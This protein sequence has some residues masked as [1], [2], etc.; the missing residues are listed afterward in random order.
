MIKK[1]ILLTVFHFVIAIQMLS[2]QQKL[3]GTI[4]DQA[5]S[6]ESATVILLDKDSTM[7]SFALSDD[8]GAFVF[9]GLDQTE[10]ILQ[11]SFMS[12]ADYSTSIN[13]KPSESLD[14]GKIYLEESS[15]I[16][17]E[18]TIKAE[19][20][21]IGIKGDTINY[22]AAAF[23][24]KP[25]ATVEELLKKMPG[26]EVGRDGSIK[27]QGEEV[28]NVLVDG[29]EFFGKDPKIATQ[30]LEAE[31][32]DKVQVFD[33][34][35]ELAEFTGIEDGKEE[36]TI[37]LKLKDGYKNGGFGNI[38]L[39]GGTEDR[40]QSKLSYNRFSPK[41][42]SSILFSANNINKQA[43]S[44]NEYIS[45]M[46]GLNSAINNMMS[47]MN[48]SEFSNGRAPQGLSNDISGGLNFNYDF[49]EKVQ[50]TSN[51][52][53]FEKKLNLL[54][55]NKSIQF[56][57]NNEFASSDEE[58]NSN[59]TRNHKINT[60][61]LIKPS[62]LIQW[63]LRN[64]LGIRSTSNSSFQ[65]SEFED[66]FG[67]NTTTLDQNLESSGLDYN[68]E[69]Q[70][71]KKY[72]KKGRNWINSIKYHNAQVEDQTNIDNLYFV[73]QENFSLNQF[74]AFDNVLKRWEGESAFT[75][76][77]NKLNFVSLKYAYKSEEESPEKAFYDIVDNQ[78]ILNTTLSDVFT[79]SLSTHQIGLSFRR[80]KKKNK[81]A[82]GINQ[83]WITLETQ[84][85]L[86]L[87][88]YARQ[89]RFV[90]PYAN[91]DIEVARNTKIDL[92]YQSRTEVPGIQQLISI[93][94][95]TNPKLLRIGNPGLRPAQI[96][97]FRIGY[98][99]FNNFDFKNLFASVS[100][101]SIVDRVVYSLSFDDNLL[102]TSKP[103]NSS[104]Y[105]NGNL[106]FTYSAPIRKLGIKYRLS[107]R[108]DWSD[109]ESFLNNE[110]SQVFE[111]E[112]SLSLTFENRKKKNFDVLFGI[113]SGIQSRA[114]QINPMFDQR[115]LNTSAFAD[116]NWFLPNNWTLTSSF[117]YTQFSNQSFSAP[118]GFKLW[119]ASVQKGFKDN[120]F[121]IKATAFDL[122]KQNVGIARQGGFNSFSESTFNTLHQY[123]MCELKY[124]I[125]K[126]RKSGISFGS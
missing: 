10:Y 43:F 57:D 96:H 45:M 25:G 31:A 35:S 72:L 106:Y 118:E 73:D 112:S 101:S 3:S 121:I 122:L 48:F 23:Q 103:I 50:W 66:L 92:S 78:E 98:N 105:L 108:G 33:K 68:G 1:I 80:N 22:N 46:G 104:R 70:R 56:L 125:G 124:R 114:Y 87:S 32:V 24:T 34:A 4:F 20:I 39:A 44:F 77:L 9:E 47:G 94:D 88:P 29:K 117:D 15:E 49:N 82:F 81:V 109:Y 30:N 79:K 113:S 63:V 61:L 6:I 60:K 37:N 69:L 84:A 42:Q 111:T 40:Y 21:P 17:K 14:L 28:E 102:G 116:L 65:N 58:Q 36:K 110:A 16:L 64:N 67:V 95:N 59:S 18:V 83:Q 52:F 54:K 89:Y 85:G 12:Y 76:P 90:L 91:W 74:Q 5:E 19:H 13:L 97:S 115:F 53:L 120:K 75:E 99:K 7:V 100:F 27:A 126:T 41:A 123:F 11:I 2:A 93:P 62:P 107:A 51:Y 86:S 26:I 38:S 119:N 8:K 55:S 71:R